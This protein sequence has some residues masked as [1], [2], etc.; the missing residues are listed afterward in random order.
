[1]SALAELEVT[2]PD[3]A[4][5]LVEFLDDV[6]AAVW[7]DLARVSAIG[8]YR[9]GLQRTYLERMESLMTEEPPTFPFGPVSQDVST[10]DIRPLV[11]EQL[12]SLRD[13]VSGRV[14]RG[15]A[16]RVTAAHLRDVLARIDGILEP[17]SG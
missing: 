2:Q 12:R 3:D 17:G 10:S 9:R 4:Y 8:T 16:D 5:P 1:M 13:V 15:N 14:D 11:R 6:R 7:Q